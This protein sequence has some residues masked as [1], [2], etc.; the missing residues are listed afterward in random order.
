MDNEERFIE[1]E[2][3]LSRQE[4]LVDSLNQTVYQQQ[5]KI[6][7]LEA[8]CNALVRQFKD[9]QTAAGDPAAAHERPPHY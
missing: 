6:D 3:K 7:H 1:I 4:D 8:L 5:K 9:G 2:I